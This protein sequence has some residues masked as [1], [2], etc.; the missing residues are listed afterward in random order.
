M[1]EPAHPETTGHGSADAHG[2]DA[3]AHDGEHEAHISDKTF[4]KV[5]GGLLVF[6][7][8]SFLANQIL[9]LGMA[10]FTIIGLVAICKA[11]LVVW[12]FMH[13]KLDFKLLYIFIIPV[14]ILAPLIVI[15]LWPDI[16]LTWRY[17]PMP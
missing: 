7:V 8:I 1:T 3:H 11:F 6:T 13:L 4:M 12:F 9:G 10:S 2:A 5:F 15:V 14:M 16:V 17:G